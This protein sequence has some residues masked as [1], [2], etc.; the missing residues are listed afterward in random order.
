MKLLK[1]FLWPVLGLA[2][3]YLCFA[4]YHLSFDPAIWEVGGRFLFVIFSIIS[5]LGIP[6]IVGANKEDKP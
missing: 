1:Y 3:L 5:A 4:F 2:L 6:L